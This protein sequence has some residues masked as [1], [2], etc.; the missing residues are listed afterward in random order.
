MDG[1]AGNGQLSAAAAAAAAAAAS[2]GTSQADK[3]SKHRLVADG[4]AVAHYL[5]K[6]EGESAL[7][8]GH[9]RRFSVDDLAACP[10]AESCWDGVRNY[11][12]RNVMLSMR[13]GDLGFFYHSNC[14]QPGI[15][16]VVRVTREAYVDHTQFD[17]HDLHYDAKARPDAPRWYMVDVQLERRLKRLVP[18]DELRRHADGALRGM[19]LLGGGRLSVQP[20]SRK[21]FDFILQLEEA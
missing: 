15:V 18:L 1:S 7:E 12:A 2:G 19:A 10:D 4:D 3:V 9:D 13:K 16:A 17:Q 8:Q 20:V 5:F 21:H 6:S 14:K 11:Q